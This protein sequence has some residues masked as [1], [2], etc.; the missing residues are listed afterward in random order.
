MGIFGKKS[1]NFEAQMQQEFVDDNWDR[2][3]EL[4]TQ[5]TG[6]KYTLMQRDHALDEIE[7]ARKLDT[8]VM[9]SL[10]DTNQFLWNERE[11]LSAAQGPFGKYVVNL[12]AWAQNSPEAEI[13]ALE[14]ARRLAEACVM[15][16]VTALKVREKRTEADAEMQQRLDDGWREELDTEI[17]AQLEADG[18]FATVREEVEREIRSERRQALIEEVVATTRAQ[19]RSDE[20]VAAQRAE[21]TADLERDGTLRKI[22]RRVRRAREQ[23][24]TVEIMKEAKQQAADRFDAD[25]DA[26]RAKIESDPYIIAKRDG[27]IATEIQRLTDLSA[28]EFMAASTDNDPKLR[29]YVEEQARIKQHKKALLKHQRELKR[30]WN[31]TKCLDLSTMPN[32]MGLALEGLI[33]GTKVRVGFMIERYDDEFIINQARTAEVVSDSGVKATYYKAQFAKLNDR[34]ALIGRSITRRSGET[35]WSSE[36]KLGS[37]VTVRS[38]EKGEN[39]V[40]LELRSLRFPNAADGSL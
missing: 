16:D 39:D 22:E 34:M 40:Q 33:A 38:D 12:I 37:T 21:I 3:Q 8:D 32:G 4:Q 17:A 1:E 35:E 19:A 24:L 36:V 28:E 6:L 9:D 26:I 18:T 30:T 23:A 13:S 5:V 7:K 11:R 10:Q 2:A 29:T 14:R 25:K 15:R 20:A 27:A 31:E